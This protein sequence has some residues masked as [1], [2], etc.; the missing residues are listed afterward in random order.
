MG[1]QPE[2]GI[3]ARD[4][5]IRAITW[6][7]ARHVLKT[8]AHL[9]AA[10]RGHLLERRGRLPEIANI[11]TASAQK[12]G[13]QWMRALFDHPI[14]RHHTGLFTVPQMDYLQRP[15][16]ALPLAT[17]VPGLY[18]DYAT[19]QKLPHSYP[20]RVI[21]MFRDPRDLVVSG[22]FSAVKTHQNTHV[23]E[24]ESLRDELRALPFDEALLRVIE[25]AAPVL[26]DVE[27][28]VD[29]SDPNVA[30]FKLEE[31]QADPATNVARM[32]DHCE[33]HLSEAEFEQ[34]LNETSREALQAKDLARREPGAESHYRVDRKGFRELF[35]AEHYAALEAVAPGLTE[36]LGYPPA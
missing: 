21:Y 35:K 36:R 34:V 28:W 26:R 6:K 31:V 23:D 19:Y 4:W 29:V 7:P 10:Q 12:A 3:R 9:Y 14:I 1:T 20:H 32:L 16:I 27:T 25:V 15:G 33:I 18:V 24:V 2:A 11:Y 5:A 22:Y 17:F 13:S 8:G 30:F